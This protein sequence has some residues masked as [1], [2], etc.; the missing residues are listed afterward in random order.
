MGLSPGVTRKPSGGRVEVGKSIEF[1]VSLT[2]AWRGNFERCLGILSPQRCRRR[3]LRYTT[4]DEPLNFEPRSSDEYDIGTGAPFPKL[5]HHTD[6]KTLSLDKFPVYQ[7]FY[8]AN[9]Q[10]S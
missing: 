3:G 1:Q 7:T 4:G 10:W 6:E 9:L 5:A 2:L 8:M